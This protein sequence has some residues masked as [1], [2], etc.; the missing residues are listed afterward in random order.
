[1]LRN[2]KL[3][4]AGPQAPPLSR[5]VWLLVPA[6]LIAL[7]GI[8]IPVYG[9][10][11]A[12]RRAAAPVQERWVPYNDELLPAA[13]AAGAAGAADAAVRAILALHRE[14][15]GLAAERGGMIPGRLRERV[16]R[17]LA[18]YGGK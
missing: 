13:D 17:I 5:A 9:D 4:E 18:Q 15:S 11:S 7:A 10:L 8:V 6:G 2:P 1:M 12:K 3:L 16:D 14:A